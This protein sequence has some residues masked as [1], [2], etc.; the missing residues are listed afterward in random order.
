[1]FCSC[2]SITCLRSL[3]RRANGLSVDSIR[4]RVDQSASSFDQEHGCGMGVG[5]DEKW[6]ELNNSHPLWLGA[7][8]EPLSYNTTWE[9]IRVQLSCLFDQV[10]ACGSEW[11][12]MGVK[13]LSSHL[14]GCCTRAAII[15][16]QLVRVD[17]S[18][19]LILAWSAAPYSS[20]RPDCV[21]STCLMVFSCCDMSCACSSFCCSISR[22]QRCLLSASFS[23]ISSCC[24]SLSLVFLSKTE[25]N[26]RSSDTRDGKIASNLCLLS[27]VQYWE[28]N[29]ATRHSPL[30]SQ[31]RRK[32]RWI[33]ITCLVTRRPHA[34][35][36]RLA[37]CPNPGVEIVW[38]L[39]PS[40]GVG[41]G[42]GS[43]RQEG[44]C[45]WLTFRLYLCGSRRSLTEDYSHPGGHNN[46]TGHMFSK[47]ITP[48]PSINELFVSRSAPFSS[49]SASWCCLTSLSA[50]LLFRWAC[51]LISANSPSSRSSNAWLFCCST[52]CQLDTKA[53]IHS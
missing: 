3:R 41:G 45:M 2:S 22:S 1:M 5:A 42:G 39:R 15:Q 19:T 4:M 51:F 27:V 50:S 35:G 46:Q 8:W 33:L 36:H 18:S 40:G 48:K 21:L 43:L 44:Y 20:A 30:P 34:T 17:H 16:Q 10:H 23:L 37:N 38:L 53:M 7:A 9:L 13:Q 14:I 24:R 25:N 31:T 49:C 12:G 6:W 32:G 28:A 11:E 52:A 29:A 47:L 26:W